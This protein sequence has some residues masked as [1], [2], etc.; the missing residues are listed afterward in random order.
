[1]TQLS[2]FNAPLTG[3]QLRSLLTQGESPRL[4]PVMGHGDLESIKNAV[5][6]L[7]LKGGAHQP[8]SDVDL[9]PV[10]H[11]ALRNAPRRVLLDARFWHWMTAVEFPSYVLRRWAP[12]VDL[13]AGEFLSPSQAGRFLGSSSLAG[14]GGNALARLFWT[15]EAMQDRDDNYSLTMRLF[16]RQDLVMGLIEREFGLLPA[17]IR[18]CARELTDLSQDERRASLTRLTLRASTVQLEG[19]SE[20]D[21]SRLLH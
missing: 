4:T 8:S 19:A 5:K 16:T 18:A 15:A 17:V 14:L 2:R 11:S 7:P 13:A 3:A 1:M 10:V 20:A 12:S 6:I 9:S 21:V